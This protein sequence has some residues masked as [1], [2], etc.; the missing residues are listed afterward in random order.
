MTVH[1]H[2]E[3]LVMEGLS[4]GSLD[5]HQVKAVVESELGSLLLSHGLGE[6][7]QN[8]G[9]ISFLSGNTIHMQSQQSPTTLGRHIARSVYGGL[10]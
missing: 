3:R 5:H 6:A 4:L 2:I 7:V 9:E 1:L 8:G 10:K